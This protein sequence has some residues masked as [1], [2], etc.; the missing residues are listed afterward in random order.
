M[1]CAFGKFDGWGECGFDLGAQP[2][3]EAFVGW[4]RRRIRIVDAELL[5]RVH[6]D[7]SS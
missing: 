1:V 2:V 3:G 6:A 4:V 7:T 5:E